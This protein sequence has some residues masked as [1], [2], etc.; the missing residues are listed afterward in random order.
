MYFFSLQNGK[1]IDLSGLQSGIRIDE[2]N[3]FLKK[4]DE[5]N[6]SIFDEKELAKFKED[7]QPYLKD[8]VL[9]MWETL[10]WF[11]KVFG[12][13]SES[14]KADN[15]AKG[16]DNSDVKELV[17]NSLIELMKSAAEADCVAYLKQNGVNATV[18]MLT[19]DNG[20]IT[21]LYDKIKEGLDDSLSP[22]Y[23]YS[24]IFSEVLS[25]N[26]LEDAQNGTLT[27]NEYIERKITIAKA[28]L[29][30]KMMN[31]YF[32]EEFANI[33]IPREQLEGVI[34]QYFDLYFYNLVEY[35]ANNYDHEQGGSF[36]VIPWSIN[37]LVERLLQDEELEKR[38][39]KNVSCT[40]IQDISNF[41]A[42]GNSANIEQ[43]YDLSQIYIVPNISYSGGEFLT[44]EQVFKME[45]GREFDVEAYQEFM[46]ANNEM[47]RIMG[48]YNKMSVMLEQTDKMLD[49]VR[50]LIASNSHSGLYDRAIDAMGQTN[51]V[52][53]PTVEAIE[54][55]CD[56]FTGYY[57]G[58]IEL[59]ANDLNEII[60]SK[61]INGLKVTI[62]PD[63]KLNIGFKK[64]VLE[65]FPDKMYAITQLL[66]GF[67]EEIKYRF[68]LVLGGKS[69]DTYIENY[70]STRIK[71]LGQMCADQIVDMYK[72]DN[73]TVIQRCTGVIKTTGMVMV[74]IGG[75]L[76][77]TPAVGVGAA[78]TAMGGKMAIGGMVADYALQYTEAL[79]RDEI[80]E[81]EL[82][83][84]SK[85]FIMDAAGFIIGFK[86]GQMGNKVFSKILDK[87]LGEVLKQEIT[88]GNR[89]QAL[90]TVISN[91][92][93]LKNFMKAAGAKIGTDFLISYVG[94]LVM[95]GILDTED[96]YL[97]LLKA[98]LLGIV[99]GTSGDLANIGHLSAK[100]QR[101]LELREQ[102][103]TSLLKDTELRELNALEQEFRQAGIDPNRIPAETEEPTPVRHQPAN[104]ESNPI[105][106]SRDI[107]DEF[108]M[109]LQGLKEHGNDFTPDFLD[110]ASPLFKE[111][112]EYRSA[113]LGQLP[114]GVR[115]GKAPDR[116]KLLIEL[117]GFIR[118]KSQIATREDYIRITNEIA[119]IM[120]AYIKEKYPNIRPEIAE[121]A[122]KIYR[123]KVAMEGQTQPETPDVN[124][125]YPITNDRFFDAQARDRA[126]EEFT[127]FLEEITGKKVLVG[128]SVRFDG[129][130]NM[131]GCF[132]NPDFYKD[133]D[134][135][136]L[137]HGT[138]SSLVT[139]ASDPNAWRFKGNGEP[140]WQYIN[141]NIPEGKQAL[142]LVCEHDGLT[143]AERQ[144]MPEMYDDNG[145]YMD[146][147]GDFVSG[148]VNY[149]NGHP[150]NGVAPQPAKIVVSG[151]DHIVGSVEGM[152]I[153]GPTELISGGMCGDVTITRYS[154]NNISSHIDL[155]NGSYTTYTDKN[156]NKVYKVVATATPNNR[157]GGYDYTYNVYKVDENGYIID[158]LSGVTDKDIR[159]AWGR[160]RGGE[161]H[162]N[163]SSDNSGYA[164]SGI[165]FFRT[166]AN[167]FTGRTETD[168]EPR[169]RNLDVNAPRTH[170]DYSQYPEDVRLMIRQ[171]CD[172]LKINDNFF[173]DDNYIMSHFL[174][175][176]ETNSII[177]K[178]K[179]TLKAYLEH[180]R[181]MHMLVN[182]QGKS[183]F[184]KQYY[185]QS[186]GNV[187]LRWDD[188]LVKDVAILMVSDPKMHESLGNLVGLFMD[189]GIDEFSFRTM[190]HYVKK[191]YISASTIDISLKSLITTDGGENVGTYYIESL[192]MSD[193]SMVGRR[194][195]IINYL[196]NSDPEI[197]N[198]LQALKT[199]IGDEIFD[200]RWEC[201]PHDDKSAIMN[202]IKDAK[203]IIYIRKTMLGPQN[204]QIRIPGWNSNNL[205]LHDIPEISNTAATMLDEGVPFDDV[206]SWVA[207]SYRELDTKIVT[208]ATDQYKLEA[209]GLLRCD[210]DGY[211]CD[212][213][214]HNMTS[215][216]G[217]GYTDIYGINYVDR[218]RAVDVWNG[219]TLH[220]PEGYNIELTRIRVSETEIRPEEYNPQNPN[221]TVKTDAI[222]VPH[223][224]EIS[225]KMIHPEGRYVNN[226]LDIVNSIQD[227]LMEKYHGKNLTEADMNDIN[228]NIGEIHWLLSHSMPWGRG[229]A[230]ISDAYVKALYKALGIQLSPPRRGVSFDLEAFCTE[231]EDYR[232]NYKNLY[233]RA[234]RYAG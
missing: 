77:V 224:Y 94:D 113:K 221:H 85:Y 166:I 132:N 175:G 31:E 234:P 2:D 102:Q 142:L 39:F 154:V 23:I 59:A 219:R 61:C 50:R 40:I 210:R 56:L 48:P 190:I 131:L 46:N 168:I 213:R 194:R 62:T 49:A 13:S 105:G 130:I 83:N 195:D 128:S 227:M 84:V 1:K 24:L 75:V 20:V 110:E 136:V 91:K 82:A 52:N 203:N 41:F 29:M 151:I 53:A 138:G 160:L 141:D 32:E 186:S 16:R 185:N 188:D 118:N 222:G 233:E 43:N 58:D 191:G 117:E 66:E 164:Y 104:D 228:E 45:R 212:D 155:Q 100:H 87:K 108:D 121:N 69:L 187:E 42:N 172:E 25:N 92:S 143:V 7:L 163:S 90:K 26:L 47:Q 196:G 144:N 97:S 125:Q 157:V 14:L 67:Q 137:G 6:N 15:A 114:Q 201:V 111:F 223:Y 167:M 37:S 197:K 230:G 35:A 60:Q 149:V 126:V 145:V 115:R 78:M 123:W 176:V 140:V 4:Y 200:L 202:F 21:E 189:G 225:G 74:V 119:D 177:F 211:L 98:N 148:L 127:A 178:D 28:M 3:E 68:N 93:L 89:M 173:S 206:M 122:D 54:N 209:S 171:V 36:D 18:D 133:F 17:E 205:W 146:A 174:E 184:T 232:R 183:I 55:I 86:A 220:V 101:Y 199:E 180:C 81:E 70:N 63:G 139:D 193:E 11:A 158:E 109:Y 106:A 99:V 208:K 217:F 9:D 95:M 88:T 182:K 30:H 207:L 231:L 120:P 22:N 71:A 96:D 226:A 152:R 124:G 103:N 216:T 38:F 134:Y 135:I 44:F 156:G 8:G 107:V 33:N 10:S 214:H 73:G 51:V 80:S 64:G 229:S 192:L 169:S 129:F 170:M 27:K 147:I 112:F 5:N 72:A 12:F 215:M 116:M 79:T 19:R 181:N 76:C 57:G 162:D 150:I 159:K 153:N 161:I 165:P 204:Y 65:T 179:N 34:S 198:A 218:F